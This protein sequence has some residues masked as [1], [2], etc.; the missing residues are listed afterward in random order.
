[1]STRQCNDVLAVFIPLPHPLVSDIP[2]QAAASSWRA[3][4]VSVWV[5]EEL[6]SPSGHSLLSRAL[7]APSASLQDPSPERCL[8]SALLPMAAAC[9]THGI[10]L[11]EARM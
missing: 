2:A 3:A 8:P 1:M 6:H 5:C 7:G 4:H 10:S 9:P 11:A